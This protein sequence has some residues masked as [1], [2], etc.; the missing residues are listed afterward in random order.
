M[1]SENELTGCHD[2]TRPAH[3]LP[4]II[5]SQFT[6]TSLWFA[7]NAVLPDLQQAWGLGAQATGHVTSAIQLGFITG[8]LVF[9]FLALADRF[10]PRWVFF[11]CSLAGGAANLAVLFAPEG[12]TGLLLLRFITGFFLAGIYPVGMK[13]AASWY[14]KGLG[15]ALGYLVGALVLGTAFPHLLRGLG[16]EMPWQQVIAGV[17]LLAVIGGLLMWWL[18][19]DGPN[20]P[21]GSAF[22]PRV[23]G[24]VFASRRF[25]ASAFGYFGH[26][27]E[28]YAFWAFVP[29]WLV[30]YAEYRG[31]PLNVSLCAFAIIAAGFV[32][33]AWGGILS[34]KFGSARVAG[35]QLLISGLC[36]LLSPLLFALNPVVLLGF[37]LLWGITVVGDSPQFSALNSANAPREYVGSALTIVNSIGFLITVFSIQLV[38]YLLPLIG[39]QAIFWLL[40]PGPVFGL[41]RLMPLLRD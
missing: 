5:F 15:R 32:G 20:L 23:F 13:I 8:T 37:L 4:V 19:P 17:S 31:T 40:L 12:L 39:P 11:L 25:R 3:I 38:E 41:W 36:C 6:G 10:S 21:K 16:A 2:L 28:L 7:A 22:N 18:V 14:E 35:L 27:W 1:S 29:A 9:A 24:L 26:M 34:A 30:A 33:C